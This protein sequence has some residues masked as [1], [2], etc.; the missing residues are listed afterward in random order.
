ME[1]IRIGD[2]PSLPKHCDCCGKKHSNRRD[3]FCNICRDL[4]GLTIFRIGMQH[5]GKSFSY[6]E[7]SD[8]AYC[9]WVLRQNNCSCQ[10]LD[11]QKYLQSKDSR[12]NEVLFQFN[13]KNELLRPSINDLGQIS[14]SQ[15]GLPTECL[16][17]SINHHEKLLTDKKSA[18]V[19][20]GLRQFVWKLFIGDNMAIGKCMCCGQNDI[21]IQNSSCECGHII[22]RK[23]GG[24]SVFQNLRPICASCNRSM[25]AT[26]M[27]EYMRD[28][29][30]DRGNP[31]GY[32][33]VSFQN[34]NTPEEYR[35]HMNGNKS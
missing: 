15:P 1:K 34:W 24:E 8:K 16:P 19:G 2:Y 7:E 28:C 31:I 10:L 9:F 6:I 26:N 33:S 21:S 12:R 20:T 23:N 29:G 35:D 27:D 5:R 30:Y 25:G 13:K 14:N 11:F 32:K 18:K 22:S 4:L 3:N 17:I